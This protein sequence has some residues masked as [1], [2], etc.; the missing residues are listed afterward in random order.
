MV[1]LGRHGAA[2]Y[3]S[4]AASIARTSWVNS[5]VQRPSLRTWK[6]FHS[7]DGSA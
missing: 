7:T 4:A 2:Q 6:I 3:R 1:H 5:G